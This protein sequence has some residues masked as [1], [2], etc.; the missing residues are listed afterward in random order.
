MFNQGAGLRRRHDVLHRA[1][2][3]LRHQGLDIH[4]VPL[5]PDQPWR[6]QIEARLAAGVDTVVAAGGDGTVNGIALCLLD[7][8]YRL[9]VV[10]LGT[11]NHFAK[12]MGLPL[13]ITAA[14]DAVCHGHTELID[15]GEVNGI[16]FLNFSSLGLYADLLHAFV[17]RQRLGWPK[18]LALLRAGADILRPYPPLQVELAKGS[19]GAQVRTPLVFVGNNRYHLGGIDLLQACGDF[20]SGILQVAYIRPHGRLALLRLLA[21][22]FWPRPQLEQHLAM[23]GLRS[24]QVLSSRSRLRVAVD[25]E[26]RLLRPPLHYQVRPQVLKVIVPKS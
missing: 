14:L 15:V 3:A 25:G 20:R 26:S 23:T 17:E 13:D 11:F 4:V 10:P 7:T 5:V 21:A 16:P 24:F 12:H 18:R 22:A 19:E 6:A 8:D 2:A 1:V 9:G